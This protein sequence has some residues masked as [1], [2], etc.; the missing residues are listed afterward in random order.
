MEKYK[1]IAMRLGGLVEV[2]PYVLRDDN[3]LKIL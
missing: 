1:G 2:L 3:C